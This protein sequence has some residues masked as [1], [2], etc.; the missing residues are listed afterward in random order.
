MRN[1]DKHREDAKWLVT[2][3]DELTV[4]LPDDEAA[5]EQ[6]TLDP[7]LERYKQLMPAI[8]ITTTTSTMVVRC[9]DYKDEI[10][11]HMQWLN[12][13]EEKVREDMPLDDMESVRVMMEEQQVSANLLT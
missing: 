10:E 5:R 13:A 9:H 11:L 7:I 4:G 3:L 6:D 1:I 2:T 8:E 12:E